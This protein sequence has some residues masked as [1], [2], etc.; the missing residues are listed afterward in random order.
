MTEVSIRGPVWRGPCSHLMSPNCS[1]MSDCR[2]CRPIGQGAG[3][4][5]GSFAKDIV[6][7]ARADLCHYAHLPFSSI[8]FA[9]IFT[10]DSEF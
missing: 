5:T 7:L 8:L 9:P 2:L 3:A 10:V 4:V 1:W 6:L